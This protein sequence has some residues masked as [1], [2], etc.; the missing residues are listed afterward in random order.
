MPSANSPAS[1]S[2]P[3]NRTPAYRRSA[4]ERGAVQAGAIRDLRDGRSWYPFSTNRSSAAVFQAL[5]RVRRPICSPSQPKRRDP[6]RIIEQSH[7]TESIAVL[8]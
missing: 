1:T 8:H 3:P 4:E 2:S 7:A 5:T 6:D